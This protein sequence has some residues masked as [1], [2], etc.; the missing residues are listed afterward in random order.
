MAGSEGYRI[1]SLWRCLDFLVVS[2]NTLYT[3][4]LCPEQFDVIV[5][6]PC[7]YTSFSFAVVIIV[8][9][10][11]QQTIEAELRRLTALDE[12]QGTNK[13]QKLS[14]SRTFFVSICISI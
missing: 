3:A 13:R 11:Q 10:V 2:M 6:S 12:S 4:L 14:A 1:V 8:A 7:C 5:L 9:V